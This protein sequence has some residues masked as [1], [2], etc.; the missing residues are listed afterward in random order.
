M[1]LESIIYVIVSAVVIVVGAILSLREYKSDYED[2]KPGRA[3]Y[4]SELMDRAKEETEQTA[5]FEEMNSI[6][7]EELLSALS[8][9]AEETEINVSKKV[10]ITY[11]YR[12]K[13]KHGI[14]V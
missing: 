5:Q 6:K 7:E 13:K 9:D 4:I 2:G 11:D 3:V 14:A 1:L 12:D 8:E 10:M